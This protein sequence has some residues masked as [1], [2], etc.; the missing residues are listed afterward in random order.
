ME[1]IDVEKVCASYN[2]ARTA[3][4][5]RKMP[6]EQVVNI[7]KENGISGA[8]AKKMAQSP[9]LFTT[10]K[11]E[12]CGRGKHIGYI[13]PTNPVHMNIIKNWIYPVKK[14]VVAN[15]KETSFEDECVAYL[16]EKGYTLKR[17]IGFNE[18]KFKQDYPQL[19]QKYLIYGDA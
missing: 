13:W 17:V 8:L 15:K 1:R 7:L 18:D 12:N 16:K 10:Y 3:N 4:A 5:G 19:Y 2:T 14:D 11:R 9:T 6:R